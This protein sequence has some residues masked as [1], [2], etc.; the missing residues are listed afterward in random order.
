MYCP[1]EI[2]RILYTEEEI[3]IKVRELGRYLT[4][5]YRNK[6]P[7]FLGVLRGATVFFCDLIRR[8]ECPIEID[9]IRASSYNNA[10]VSNGKPS[11]DI[12]SPE[13]IRGRD[14]VIVED[15]LDTGHT[16]YEIKNRIMEAN[17]NS[18]KTVVLL[19]KPSRH[20]VVGFSAD[21]SCFEIE[22]HFVVGYGLDYAQ[23]YRNLSF[24]GL[25][26]PN[27]VNT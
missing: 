23:K 26:D 25:L 13:S 7:L 20:E 8:I 3:R 16:L 4:E 18:V 19:N 14:V 2:E 6:N 12:V 11:V 15:I 22:D 27:A 1:E 5:E 9:F 21:Y 24:I 17:P 10:S